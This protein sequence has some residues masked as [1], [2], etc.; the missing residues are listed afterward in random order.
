VPGTVK[1]VWDKI[2]KGLAWI[3]EK[4]A[5]VVTPVFLTLFYIT[6]I[7]IAGIVS[8]LVRA[9]LLHRR[10]VGNPT[11]WFPKPKQQVDE[12]RYRAQF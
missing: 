3:G 8:R 2:R 11:F 9:D 4:I 6:V 1:R 5:I 10:A 12:K 7:G